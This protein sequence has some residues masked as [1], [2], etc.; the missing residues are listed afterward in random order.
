LCGSPSQVKQP[1]CSSAPAMRACQHAATFALIGVVFWAGNA[2]GFAPGR[3][4]VGLGAQHVARFSWAGL[5]SLKALLDQGA[6]TRRAATA[7]AEAE[8]RW[9]D[10]VRAQAAER[11]ARQQGETE[12]QYE[13]RWRAFRG[14]ESRIDMLRRVSYQAPSQL[15]IQAVVA[16]ASPDS[17]FGSETQAI[18][19]HTRTETHTKT[20]KRKNTLTHTY[21]CASHAL[22]QIGMCIWLCD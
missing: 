21:I 19:T 9:H 13:R 8:A 18:R 1:T 2:H 4:I 16:A 17:I 20:R 3:R 6:R 7:K 12:Q 15:D 10:R 11:D 22:I 5:A 14:R